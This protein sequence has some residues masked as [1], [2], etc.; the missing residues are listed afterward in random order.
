MLRLGCRLVFGMLGLETTGSIE[1]NAHSCLLWSEDMQVEH[2]QFC[3]S[4]EPNT[5][6]AIKDGFNSSHLSLEPAAICSRNRR[7]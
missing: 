7:S 3:A 2:N 5:F 6:D 4:L 1:L